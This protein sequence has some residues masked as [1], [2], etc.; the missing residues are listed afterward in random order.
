MSWPWEVLEY[1]GQVAKAH[2]DEEET[3]SPTILQ[4]EGGKAWVEQNPWSPGLAPVLN[5]QRQT[6][7][8]KSREGPQGRSYSEQC[9]SV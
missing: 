2:S 7:P 3:L 4:G 9:H 8:R 6:A 1:G 5:H